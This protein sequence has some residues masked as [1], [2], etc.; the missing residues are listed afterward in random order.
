ML[1]PLVE[2]RIGHSGETLPGRVVAPPVKLDPDACAPA[3]FDHRLADIGHVGNQERH[4]PLMA[5][6]VPVDVMAAQ[7]I[8]I[9]GRIV[10]LDLVIAD[11]SVP[12]AVDLIGRHVR[13]RRRPF[14]FHAALR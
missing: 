4:H 6:P 10:D 13:G 7:E 9:H 5:E 14:A 1:E 11:P 2:A 3:F 8:G 12:A